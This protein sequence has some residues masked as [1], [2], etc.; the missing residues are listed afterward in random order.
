MDLG[1]GGSANP[2]LIVI[3]ETGKARNSV[4]TLLFRNEITRST[5]RKPCSRFY[6]FQGWWKCQ[7]PAEPIL[8]AFRLSKVFK[9]EEEKFKNDCQIMFFRNTKYESGHFEKGPWRK[10]FELRLVIS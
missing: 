2:V 9:V 10:M 8:L 7:G 3:R 6:D 1:V 4:H 5:S